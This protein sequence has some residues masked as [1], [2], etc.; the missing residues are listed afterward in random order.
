MRE[1]SVILAG[2]EQLIIYFDV[3]FMTALLLSLSSPT[4]LAQT[5]K[6]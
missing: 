6:L 1:R 5:G 4:C 3:I 2:L